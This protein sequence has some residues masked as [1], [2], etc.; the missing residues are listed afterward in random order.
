MTSSTSYVDIWIGM[1]YRYSVSIRI[2][3]LVIR[4]LPNRRE[5]QLSGL[6]ISHSQQN[7]MKVSWIDVHFCILSSFAKKNENF[8]AFG[9]V[10]AENWNILTRSQPSVRTHYESRLIDRA[11]HEVPFCGLFPRLP[12]A[13]NFPA[14]IWSIIFI[15]DRPLLWYTDLDEQSLEASFPGNQV[16]HLQAVLTNT[17]CSLWT[18]EV[19]YNGTCGIVHKGAPRTGYCVKNDVRLIF[20]VLVKIDKIGLICWL[21]YITA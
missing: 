7:F 13:K 3:Q 2:G 4:V 9:A 5:G 19:P 21:C 18:G 11:P 14:P 16:T 15:F 1:E 8:I 10:G 17:W 6:L 12:F 20:Q